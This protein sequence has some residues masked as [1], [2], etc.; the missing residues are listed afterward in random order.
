MRVL[1]DGVAVGT[2]EASYAERLHSGRPV[3]AR[4]P[5]RSKFRRLERRIVHA[6][7]D[8]GEPNLPRWTSDRQS[9]SS[10]LARRAG[11][12]SRGG[13]PAAR[14]E[15]RRGRSATGCG[16]VRA[17]PGAAAVL[18]ELF[19]AQEQWSEVPDASGLLVEE[20]PAPTATAWSTPFTP[21]CTARRARRSG[22]RPR[23]GWAGGS[24][25]T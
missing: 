14:A 15:E 16:D 8:R 20:S 3:R 2:L 24:V 7:R 18:V 4:R 19:E 25:A 17:R 22:A 9:L 12:L 13:G 6:R 5:R 11:R 10:E 23:P 21:R 1:A